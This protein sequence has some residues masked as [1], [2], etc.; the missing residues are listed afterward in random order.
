MAIQVP[1]CR[2]LP[3]GRT[4]SILL[5]AFFCN[6]RQT[7]SPLVSVR[8]VHLYSSIDTNAAWKKLRFILSVRSDFHITDSS[9]I[10]VNAFANRVLM[11]FLVDETLLPRYVNLSTSFGRPPFSVEMIKAHVLRFVC[12][13]MEAYVACCSFQAM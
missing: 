1:F 5:A 12:V 13:D 11:S 7:F 9:S 3:P 10:V 8:V 6:C 4:C 2:V